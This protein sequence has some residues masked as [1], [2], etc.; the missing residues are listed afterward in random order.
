MA[1]RSSPRKSVAPPIVGGTTLLGRRARARL[2]AAEIKC[3]ANATGILE[4]A[5]WG[6]KRPAQPAP[7]PMAWD[8]IDGPSIS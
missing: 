8:F 7:D 5:S 6:W 3:E 2:D 1:A 4:L